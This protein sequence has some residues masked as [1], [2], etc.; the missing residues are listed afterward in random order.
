MPAEDGVLRQVR[1]R[2]QGWMWE[3]S[4]ASMLGTVVLWASTAHGT[5]P[6]PG[7]RGQVASV[8]PQRGVSSKILPQLH[9]R[10]PAILGALPSR[11]HLYLI[12]G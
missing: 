5:P 1:R 6:V 2:C 12:P 10:A 7:F 9:K 8:S 4:L 3:R 11:Y